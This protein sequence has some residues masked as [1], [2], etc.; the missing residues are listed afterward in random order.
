M[1]FNF[2]NKHDYRL[3]WQ[4]SYQGNR[5]KNTYK[6]LKCGKEVITIVDSIGESKFKGFIRFCPVKDFK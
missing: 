6:C 2:F 5:V 1:F 4:S 3:I